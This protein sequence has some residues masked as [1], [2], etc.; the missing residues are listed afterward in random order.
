MRGHVYTWYGSV[1]CALLQEA[2]E[3]YWRNTVCPRR[4]YKQRWLWTNG[5][6]LRRSVRRTVL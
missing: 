1:D 6:V 4:P 2:T 3:R 5:R